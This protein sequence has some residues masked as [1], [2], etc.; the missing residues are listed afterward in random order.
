MNDEAVQC[1][2]CGVE[3]FLG[4]H[5][6]MRCGAQ[7]SGALPDVE[8]AFGEALAEPVEDEQSSSKLRTADRASLNLSPL[9]LSADF[10]PSRPTQGSPDSASAPR[11]S[12][13]PSAVPFMEALPARSAGAGV[14]RE[15][16]DE[17]R[18]SPATMSEALARVSRLPDLSIDDIDDGFASIQDSGAK[19]PEFGASEAAASASAAAHG[20][21]RGALDA[22]TRQLAEQNQAF[23]AS[24]RGWSRQDQENKRRLLR[25]RE[26]TLSLVKTELAELGELPL[27]AQLEKLPFE[28][29]LA[30]LERFLDLEQNDRLR[31]SRASGEQ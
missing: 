10:E 22:L 7:L 31:F 8:L 25:K 23:E 24:R 14:S 17:S 20:V 29:K 18:A 1:P 15:I 5:F 12:S 16:P 9:S 11:V 30:E 28:R 21:H 6:C 4:A 2:K 26:E 13:R 19:K 3:M 27:I